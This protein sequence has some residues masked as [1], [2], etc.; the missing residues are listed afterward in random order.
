M[1]CLEGSARLTNA[2]VPSRDQGPLPDEANH[3]VA[4]PLAAVGHMTVEVP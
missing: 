4:V 1:I 2:S 3:A